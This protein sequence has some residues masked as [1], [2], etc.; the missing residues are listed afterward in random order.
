MAR[1]VTSAFVTASQAGTVFPFYLAEIWDEDGALRVW[2]G[3]G[4]LSWGGYTWIGTGTLGSVSAIQETADLYAAGADF[5]LQGAPGE[6]VSMA[7]GTMR[8]GLPAKLYLGFFD[9]DTGAI[10]ADPALVFEGLTDVPEIEDSGADSV[11]T[12]S[13]ENEL[14][15]L[16]TPVARRYTHEDQQINYPGDKGFEY[17]PTLQDVKIIFGA[18]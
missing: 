1:N 7:L 15:R 18:N 14:I 2:T 6:L 11:I 5:A 10:V 3:Y 12:I 4:D 16:E 8:Q 13:A 17:V 9:A